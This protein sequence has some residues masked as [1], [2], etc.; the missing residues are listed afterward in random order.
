MPTK[1]NRFHREGGVRSTPEALDSVL[2]EFALWLED[3]DPSEKEIFA[4]LEP[5]K[6]NP[7]VYRELLELTVVCISIEAL[8]R[9][10]ARARR[11]K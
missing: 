6:R 2:G 10:A 3:E 1:G 11:K 8:H 7:E 4:F 5:Y 9:H